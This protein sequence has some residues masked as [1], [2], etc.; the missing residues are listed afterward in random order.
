M[1]QLVTFLLLLGWLA[2]CDHGGAV[3]PAYEERLGGPVPDFAPMAGVVVHSALADLSPDLVA[4]LDDIAGPGLL[5]EDWFLS[6]DTMV[7]SRDHQ[8]IYVRRAGGG[9][10]SVG[11]QSDNANRAAVTSI[12]Y[13]EG[14]AH[15]VD[16][17]V[18][19]LHQNGNLV[20]NGHTVFVSQQLLRENGGRP[21]VV[22]RFASVLGRRATDVVVFPEMP[23]EQTGHVDMWLLLVDEVTAMV[24]ELR[25]E[26]LVVAFDDEE[27]A[28]ATAVAGFLDDRAADL[29]ARGFEVHR[30]PMIAPFRAASIDPE[31]RG[32]DNVFYSPANVLLF[33]QRGQRSVFVPA[34]DLDDLLPGAAPLQRAYQ[35]EWSTWFAARGWTPRLVDST[36]LGRYLGLIRCVTAPIPDLTR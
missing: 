7:W 26:A 19:L 13:S 2:A 34:A 25:H 29:R 23:G 9:V 14:G 1:R 5:V 10:G 4:A 32:L 33:N 8:P 21:E 18:S 31:D 12:D 27:F 30:L 15:P 11:Y 6:D 36:T 17:V 20:T 16:T 24:P 35:A 22:E 28:L 3:L